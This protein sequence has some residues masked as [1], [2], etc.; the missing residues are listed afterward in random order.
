MCVL[1]LNFLPQA[2]KQLWTSEFKPYVILVK[3]VVQERRKTPPLSP[4]SEDEA[5]LPVSEVSILLC[6]RL[7]RQLV[8]WVLRV[9]RGC[10]AAVHVT[11][12]LARRV[13]PSMCTHRRAHTGVRTHTPALPAA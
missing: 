6:W 8:A 5:A 4:A 10:G 3:P 12:G 2:L 9:G 11:R 7:R 1:I 13:P